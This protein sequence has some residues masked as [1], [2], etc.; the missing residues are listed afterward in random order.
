MKAHHRGLFVSTGRRES[1]GSYLASLPGL[2]DAPA[3][4]SGVA[5]VERKVT[6]DER[7]PWR[8]DMDDSSVSWRLPIR[9]PL[10]TRFTALRPDPFVTVPYSKPRA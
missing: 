8:W 9:R 3:S 1:I 5:V 4:A 2:R 10:L 6:K 7:N